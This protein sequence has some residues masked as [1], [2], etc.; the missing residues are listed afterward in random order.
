MWEVGRLTSEQAIGQILQLI[1][2]DRERMNEI[3]KRL[4]RADY[5]WHCPPGQVS[6]R[7]TAEGEGR[8]A[9]TVPGA[10]RKGRGDFVVSPQSNEGRR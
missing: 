1:R 8:E 5:P 9:T 2:E 3:E 6:P 10:Q 4:K 7:S